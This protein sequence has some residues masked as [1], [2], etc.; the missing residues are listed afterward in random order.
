MKSLQK[1]EVNLGA[2]QE[3]LLIPLLG[4]AKFTQRQPNF[5]YDPKA[6]EIVERLN[7]DFSKWHKSSSLAGAILRTRMMD[8]DVTEFLTQN[9]HGTVIEI[10]CGLNTRFERLDNGTLRWFDLDLPDTIALR[11]QF[12]QDENR[13]QMI[14]A[15]V[16][17][18]DWMDTVAATSGPW[19][20]VSEAVLIYLEAAQVQQAIAQIAERFPGAWLLT[21]TTAT[22]MVAN[23]AKHDAMRHL[24]KASWF[25]WACDDPQQVERWVEG[26]KLVRSRTFLD[27]DPNLFKFAPFP[28]GLLLRFAPWLLKKRFESYRL[29]K[30]I[31][32]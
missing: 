30:F 14:A 28:T 15:S 16:L 24:P 10:G 25:R 8:E 27:A 22:A 26:M 7:Y 3:T 32:E 11:R 1:V 9:P 19:C 6:V 21:D 5:I 20:F 31:V 17:E 18:T 12:F 4:R 29:N 23:Q 2:V 13:R